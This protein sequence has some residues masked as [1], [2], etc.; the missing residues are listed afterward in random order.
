MFFFRSYLHI[1]INCLIFIEVIKEKIMADVYQISSTTTN[2]VNDIGDRA[3]NVA[4]SGYSGTLIEKINS[5]LANNISGNTVNDMDLVPI[6]DG[7]VLKAI[8]P[9]NL[10]IALEGMIS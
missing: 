4:T 8:T 9:E 10:A 7:G 5:A 2:T 6:I 1:N 3:L